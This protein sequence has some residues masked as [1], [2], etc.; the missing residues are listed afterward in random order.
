MSHA[1][2][3]I[4]GAS[5]IVCCLS[6]YYIEFELTL[7]PLKMLKNIYVINSVN[8]GNETQMYCIDHVDIVM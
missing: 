7:Q 3:K 4:L 2:S 8:M 5:E 1:L 6:R